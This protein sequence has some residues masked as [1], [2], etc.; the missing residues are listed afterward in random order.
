MP[1]PWGRYLEGDK[2]KVADWSYPWVCG[3]CTAAKFT[4]F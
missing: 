4:E 1:E 2:G 3:N